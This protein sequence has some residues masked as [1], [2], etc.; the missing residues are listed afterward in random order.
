MLTN[1][2]CEQ[3]KNFVRTLET[4]HP[5]VGEKTRWAARFVGKQR[6]NHIKGKR[7]NNKLKK[8]IYENE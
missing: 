7:K 2:F 3:K 8:D 4:E 5:V 1:W 6:K